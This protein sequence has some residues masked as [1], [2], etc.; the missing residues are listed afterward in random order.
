MGAPSLGGDRRPL[1]L[2]GAEPQ[3]GGDRRVDLPLLDV[4]SRGLW[5]PVEDLRRVI[6]EIPT[7]QRSTYCD[8][9]LTRLAA[10]DPDQRL[11]EVRP[12]R[13]GRDQRVRIIMSLSL[14]GDVR[15]GRALTRLVSDSNAEVRHAAITALGRL[16]D[17]LSVPALCDVLQNPD[18]TTQ[19]RIA[20]ADSL[21]EIATTES[22]LGL[23][24]SLNSD[25]PLVRR[26]IVVALGSSSG[27]ATRSAL[28]GVLRDDPDEG[29][30]AESAHAL[31]R[32]MD[33]RSLLYLWESLDDP[34][35][36]V[37]RAALAAIGRFHGEIVRA[38]LSYALSD[39]HADIRAQA[40]VM[41]HPK[42]R[43]D[44]ASK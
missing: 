34:A 23:I 37:R 12:W 4:L 31:G 16:R 28:I 27:D 38:A 25:P 43:S 1:V 21:A 10:C 36:G 33:I 44:S 6:R 24:Q 35:V 29:V 2:S 7:T 9:L 39:A 22:V 18:H 19:D 14:L 26:K 15:A 30:R 3:L 41:L 40:A 11:P 32:L 17:A 5:V 20:S 42:R 13:G 8:A